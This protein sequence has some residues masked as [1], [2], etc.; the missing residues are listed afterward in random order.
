MCRRRVLYNACARKCQLT[1]S[2]RVQIQFKRDLDDEIATVNR[3]RASAEEPRRTRGRDV[4][5]DHRRVSTSIPFQASLNRKTA[6]PVVAPLRVAFP[7]AFPTIDIFPSRANTRLKNIVN[8]FSPRIEHQ[9]GLY[10]DSI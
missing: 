2:V 6:P 10:F 4:L 9:I 1:K 5:Y 7:T 8:G 3:R